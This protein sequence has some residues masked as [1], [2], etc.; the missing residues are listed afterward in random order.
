MPGG[1]L[2]AKFD[3]ITT[4][5]TYA[6]LLGDRKGIEKQ[7]KVWDKVIV[8]RKHELSE[9]HDILTTVKKRGVEEYVYVNNHYSGHGPATA[10]QFLKLWNGK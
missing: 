6:R 2:F 5:F 7:T 4:D 3:P 9:W 8:D 1:A 10:Q